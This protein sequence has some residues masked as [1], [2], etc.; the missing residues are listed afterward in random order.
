MDKGKSL[1]I[2][3]VS[4]IISHIDVYIT[5]NG[6]HIR[7]PKITDVIKDN[8]Y[9]CYRTTSNP[10]SCRLCQPQKYDRAKEKENVHSYLD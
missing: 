3:R 9:N 7:N 10:C 8:G 6:N 1:Y 2:K 5:R 4:K